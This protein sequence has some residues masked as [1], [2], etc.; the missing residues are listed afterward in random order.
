MPR[1]RSI[2]R[3]AARATGTPFVPQPKVTTL[4]VPTGTFD[5]AGK[6]ITRPVVLGAAHDGVQAQIAQH[7]LP[8][9]PQVIVVDR[10][11]TTLEPGTWDGKEVVERVF[12]N[13]KPTSATQV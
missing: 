3:Q 5:E 11:P 12:P 8:R 4:A 2:R 1:N 9:K 13:D 10:G 7:T 6:P